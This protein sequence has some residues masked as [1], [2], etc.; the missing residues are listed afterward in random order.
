M[1]P[2]VNKIKCL[3]P[4]EPAMALLKM[5]APS[6]QWNSS[7]KQVL[8]LFFLIAFLWWRMDER[9]TITSKHQLLGCLSGLPFIT[10]SPQLLSRRNCG[11]GGVGN[12]CFDLHHLAHVCLFVCTTTTT[13]TAAVARFDGSADGDDGAWLLVTVVHFTT[14]AAEVC[15]TKPKRQRLRDRDSKQ[16]H[17]LGRSPKEAKV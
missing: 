17:P 6:V 2:T 11:S 10:S 1:I 16:E 13:T 9:K 4:I 15:E 3:V 12:V 7:E 5:N 14:G 8:V